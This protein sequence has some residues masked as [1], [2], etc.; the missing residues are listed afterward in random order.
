[1]SHVNCGTCSQSNGVNLLL[2][3]LGT[4]TSRASEDDPTKGPEGDTAASKI[5]KIGHDIKTACPSCAC[6]CHCV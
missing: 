3:L 1:M 6:M 4:M 5:P 2:V